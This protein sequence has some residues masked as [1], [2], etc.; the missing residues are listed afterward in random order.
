MG[1]IISACGLPILF[2]DADAEIIHTRKWRVQRRSRKLGA[3]IARVVSG[4]Y[5][6]DVIGLHVFLLGKREE[7]VIDHIDGN[8]LNNRRSNLR[9]CIHGQNVQNS[10]TS[11][12]NKI[13][14]KG[15]CWSPRQKAWKVQVVKDGKRFAAYR[16]DLAEAASLATQKRQELHGEFACHG[17]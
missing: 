17:R 6:P 4:R 8:P 5:S 7:M 14:V 10:K 13:G 9:F 15:V 12:I 16:K 2:D 3:G 11:K 1:C